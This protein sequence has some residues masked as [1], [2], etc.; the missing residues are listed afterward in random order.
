MQMTTRSILSGFAVGG[1]STLALSLGG[2]DRAQ[3]A[4]IV[5]GNTGV[6]TYSL[7]TPS[8]PGTATLVTALPS[9]P[10]IPN[11]GTSSWIGPSGNAIDVAGNYTYSTTFSLAGLEASTAQISGLWAGDN[12]GVSLFL[13]GSSTGITANT[14]SVNLGSFTPFTIA[15]S[16]GFVAGT[17]TL[18]F[19]INN[20]DGPGVTPTGL[21][22]EFTSATADAI[23]PIPPSTAV[24]EPSD[25]V[26]TAFAFGSV[27]LLKRKLSKKTVKLDRFSK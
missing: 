22:V 6:G 21:R 18:S 5:L 3:A 8:G 15:S 14:G 16:A 4:T 12:A 19:T 17:N 25:L 1:L 2:F 9:P 7:T 20:I 26:G 23:P 24:P 11:S 27:V 10:W 13:N